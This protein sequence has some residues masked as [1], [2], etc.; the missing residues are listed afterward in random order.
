MNFPSFIAKKVAFSGKKS[1]SNLIIRFAI[2]TVALS[3]SVMIISTSLMNGFKKEI[4]SK[5][6]GFWGHIHITDADINQSLADTQPILKNQDFYPNLDTI[7]RIE[8]IKFVERFGREVEQP[9]KTNAGIKKIQ[10]Y[11]LMP[12]IIKTDENLEG[13]I[14]KGVDRDFDW[15]FLNDYLVEGAAISLP[16][17]GMSREILI[18]QQT[19]NRLNLNLGD[20]FRIHFIEKGEELKRQFSVSGIYKTGIGEYDKRFA[21]VDIRQIQKLRKWNANE[22]TGFEVFLEDISDLDAFDEF[23]YYDVLPTSLYAESIKKKFREIFE[24][25]SLQDINEYVILLLM[26]AVSI[27]NMITSLLI[28]ILERTTMIGILKSLGGTNW[29]VRKIFLYYAGYII[30]MGLFWGNLIGLGLCYIQDNFGIIKLSE[31]NYYLKVA[32]ISIDYLKVLALNIGTLIVILISLLIPTY[33][34]S[35]IDPVKAIRFK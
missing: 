24:W 15:S 13:I 28:L 35:R 29:A 16:D 32:P 1:F 11:A 27:I 33:L 3:I 23:I 5:I 10:V 25:L 4:S 26:I 22:I 6:F 19:A 2:I 34:V 7:G 18:S 8:Y 21:I 9:V 20:K 17:S 30:L 31:E 14:L 12:G